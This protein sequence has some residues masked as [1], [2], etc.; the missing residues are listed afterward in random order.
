MG[1]RERLL[2]AREGLVERQIPGVR[3]ARYLGDV[4]REVRLDKAARL[5]GP[6]GPAEE[7]VIVPESRAL[8]AIRG[9]FR[10]ENPGHSILL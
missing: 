2:D 3:L 7:F 5:A 8:A 6:V 4:D 9:L 10:H 1:E